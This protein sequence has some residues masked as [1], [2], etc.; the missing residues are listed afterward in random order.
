VTCAM[1]SEEVRYLCDIV[2]TRSRRGHVP[3]GSGGEGG[4][5]ERDC[6]VEMVVGNED[7]RLKVHSKGSVRQSKK[8]NQLPSVALPSEKVPGACAR[9]MV[10]DE[11]K[12]L[13]S[14]EGVLQFSSKFLAFLSQT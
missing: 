11:L 5:A 7:V 9:Q 10:H 2:M 13:R 1:T 14:H 3:L 6:T 4:G 8:K 12:Q